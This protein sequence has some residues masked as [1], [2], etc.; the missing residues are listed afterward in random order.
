M[1]TKQARAMS[2]LQ[3]SFRGELLKSTGATSGA[4]AANTFGSALAAVTAQ[5]TELDPLC[6]NMLLRINV[7][8]HLVACTGSSSTTCLFHLRTLAR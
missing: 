2:A 3:N 1:E 6:L 5:E 4:V 7:T 8:E